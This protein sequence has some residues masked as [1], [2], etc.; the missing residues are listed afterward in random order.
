MHDHQLI[1]DPHMAV[2]ETGDPSSRVAG[3]AG[4][5]AAPGSIDNGVER[6]VPELMD[7]RGQL[8]P[9]CCNDPMTR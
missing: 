1:P 5:E 9:H 7:S 6:A 4:T 2:L 8:N 3:R